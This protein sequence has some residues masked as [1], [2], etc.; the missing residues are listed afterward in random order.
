M[1]IKKEHIDY[2][3]HAICADSKAPTLAEYTQKGLSAKRWR[4]DLLYR[5]K[6]SAWISDNIYPYADDTHID[7]ALRHITGTNP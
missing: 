4:W 7:T 3:K 5:A 6:I 1:K 2:M